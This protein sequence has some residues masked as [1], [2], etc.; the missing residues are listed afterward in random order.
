MSIVVHFIEQL[1]D[2]I[3]CHP[4]S[5]LI[6]SISSDRRALSNQ[7]FLLGAYMIIMLRRQTEDVLELFD[8]LDETDIEHFR[9]A[10][11]APDTFGLRLED[12]WRGLE[13][14]MALAWVQPTTDGEFWGDINIREYR[15]YA[16]PCNGDFHEVVPGTFIAF[17]GPKNLGGE[18]YIDD[19]RGY[20]RFSPAYYANIF[21][22]DFGVTAVVRLNEPEYDAAA[23][24]ERCIR[25]H[26]LHFDDCTCPPPHVAR[27][28]LAATDLAVGGG[29]AVA[30]HCKA[31]LG[32]TGTL[33]AVYMM[34]SLGFGA[35]EAMGWLRMMRPGSVIGPQQHFLCAVEARPSRSLAA[36]MGIFGGTLDLTWVSDEGGK[37][38]EKHEQEEQAQA[39]VL[40][41]VQEEDS[42]TEEAEDGSTGR[43]CE[44]GGLVVADG[45]MEAR[46]LA[47]E[48][49]EGM[50]R[51]AA[52]RMQRGES[53]R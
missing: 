42:E 39:Q 19:V 32:R 26:H 44:E 25:H 8:W 21:A 50:E 15:H 49:A 46:R 31:G 29:G 33:I 22:G 28:F 13:K 2:D 36:E 53:G 30:V 12:C 6:Y 41:Q 23:F 51:R 4:D 27:A 16:N 1:Q 45:A 38:I 11:F 7:V 40:L 24:E 35:R 48:V 43:G 17:S 52:A 47:A 20:R 3:E 14:A 5:K 37:V 18:E 10:T 34:R 9:D